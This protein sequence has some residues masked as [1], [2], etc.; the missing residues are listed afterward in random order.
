MY[1][2]IHTY[3]YIL[4]HVYTYIYI[5]IYIYVYTYIYIYIYMYIYTYTCM[6]IYIYI[7]IYL[8]IYTYTCRCT[9]KEMAV[10][11][12]IIPIW[13]STNVLIVLVIQVHAGCLCEPG[14]SIPSPPAS[15]L[16][17]SLPLSVSRTWACTLAVA[18]L[19]PGRIFSRSLSFSPS[20]ARTV[21]ST[22]AWSSTN[23]N[24]YDAFLWE[25]R[26]VI[27]FFPDAGPPR[28]IADA[29]RVR[30]CGKSILRTRVPFLLPRHLN[31]SNL[32]SQD[33]KLYR[34]K[35]TLSFKLHT[36]HHLH[37]S[38]A[39]IQMWHARSSEHHEFYDLDIK[40]YLL[41]ITNS[42]V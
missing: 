33:H 8:Y 27:Y 2:Y 6:N 10:A 25:N 28:Q 41:N 11:L 19:L 17:L 16:M 7:C 20:R 31:I 3:V 34:L 12:A 39:M 5:C 1:I 35:V 15:P 23:Q 14:K 30:P 18:R 4:I 36:L 32:M 22:G 13:S 40:V 42:I 37:I 24:V 26:L 9:R 38:D 21:T 29:N